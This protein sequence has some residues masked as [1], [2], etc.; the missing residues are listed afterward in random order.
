MTKLLAKVLDIP[1]SAYNRLIGRL[2]EISGYPSE[3]IRL[4]SEIAADCAKKIVSLGLDPSDTNAE[5]LYH[6]LQTRYNQS[7]QIFARSIGEGSEMAVADRYGLLSQVLGAIHCG[8]TWA[9][10]PAA[11][12]KLLI[13]NQPK[14]TMKKLGYRSLD[15]LLKREE[16][17]QVLAIAW[18]LES[19]HWQSLLNRMVAKL[20]PSSVTL[21]KAKIAFASPKLWEN[22]KTSRP[23]VAVRPQVG[24]VLVWPNNYA[25]NISSL[26]VAALADE[27]LS[28]L[29]GRSTCLHMHHMSG[30]FTK[31]SAKCWQEHSSQALELAG[32]PISWNAIWRYLLKNDADNSLAE[33]SDPLSEIDPLD[34]SGQ[35]SYLDHL[36]PEVGWWSD[37]AH[38]VY[39]DKTGQV[40]SLNMA[41]VAV[42]YLRGSAF[43]DQTSSHARARLEDELIDRYL[44]HQGVAKYVFSHLAG[45]SALE[46]QKVVPID[47]KLKM[48]LSHRAGTA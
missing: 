10:K 25:A 26:G 48:K 22:S 17:R 11:V 37:C 14:R 18:Q 2:E 24:L 41:D 20:P 7:A 46:A 39:T 1:E 15:S 33:Q 35:E 21:Q 30:D 34:T 9:L 38:L 13:K 8:K 40:T 32:Q 23:L 16:A 36:H 12:K 5:E 6:G 27:A 3:D 43:S 47:S 31:I 19:S 28:N 45:G 29:Y 44:S 42:N 4:S